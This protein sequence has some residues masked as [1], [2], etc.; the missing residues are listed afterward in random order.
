MKYRLTALERAFE[1][2]RSGQYASIAEIKKR[3]AAD[4]FS[5]AQLTGGTLLRQLRDLIRT[6]QDARAD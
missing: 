3:L 1:M 4:G 2:A 5:V 6:A